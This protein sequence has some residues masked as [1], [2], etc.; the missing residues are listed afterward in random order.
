ME[1]L[2]PTTIYG[3]NNVTDVKKGN[4]VQIGGNMRE[5]LLTWHT[6]AGG[7]S[8]Y[9]VELYQ[10]NDRTLENRLSLQSAI[11]GSATSVELQFAWPGSGVKF[12]LKIVTHKMGQISSYIIIEDI[13]KL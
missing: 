6:P 9:D 12:S 1:N 7:A 13:D 11:S 5:V 2:V 3:N 10:T 4:A 8:S